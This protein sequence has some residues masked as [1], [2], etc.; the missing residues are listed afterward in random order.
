MRRAAAMAVTLGAAVWV[1]A[2]C[3]SSSS[4]LGRSSSAAT[5][6]SSAS[7]RQVRH[8]ARPAAPSSRAPAIVD[9]AAVRR[10]PRLPWHPG[11]VATHLQIDPYTLVTGGGRIFAVSRHDQLVRLDPRSGRVA[12]Q[13]AVRLGDDGTD[14]RPVVAGGLVWTLTAPRSAT[15]HGGT[16]ELVGYRPAGLA[17]A[18][19]RSVRWRIA[20][21]DR[22]DVVTLLAASRRHLY[23][24]A[25]RTVAELDP[26][27]G[28]RVARAGVGGTVSALTVRPDDSRISVA[29]GPELSSR[30]VTLAPRHL[31]EIGGTAFDTDATV[32][33]LVATGTGLFVS[34]A[35]GNGAQT[36]FRGAGGRSVAVT[37]GGGG[38]DQLVTVSDGVAWSGGPAQLVCA[39]PGGA[40]RAAAPLR[41]EG[42][43]APQVTTLGR[44]VYATAVG[45]RGGADLVRLRPPRVC[46]GP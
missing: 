46:G 11:L 3:T 24:A 12:A 10:A 43:S 21:H 44:H 29:Y 31:T 2:A 4:T 5:P 40:V 19:R 41:G 20:R 16:A 9:R 42:T 22:R 39:A 6:G 34:T 45:R 14:G 27:S 35:T 17:V 15:T 33:Q 23:L 37:S 30:V 25:G 28:R 18:V 32:Y 26:R 7:G 8:P 1:V 13:G 38:A 36:V